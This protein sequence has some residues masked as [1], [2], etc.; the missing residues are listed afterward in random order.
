VSKAVFQFRITTAT[1][2]FVDPPP[3]FAEVEERLID[4][5]IRAA[6]RR[7]DLGIIGGARR[8]SLC[9]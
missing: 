7:S 9:G 5:T 6:R 1:F 8:K 4:F 2:P 3:G